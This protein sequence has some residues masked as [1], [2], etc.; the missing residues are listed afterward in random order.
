MQ[1]RPRELTVDLWLKM[2][3]RKGFYLFAHGIKQHL[4]SI[5]KR[6]VVACFPEEAA[7]WILDPA[8]PHASV[9]MAK[10]WI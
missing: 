5:E 8:L 10:L 3:P 1:P 2:A 7:Q 9:F 6:A 4:T